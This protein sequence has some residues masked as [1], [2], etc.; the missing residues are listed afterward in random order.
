MICNQRYELQKLRIFFSYYNDYKSDIVK[1]IVEFL[2]KKSC[3]S[4]Q[5][6]VFDEARSFGVSFF[7]C[8]R[9]INYVQ[10]IFKTRRQE[11]S[12]KEGGIFRSAKSITSMR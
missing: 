4:S 11:I 6:G 7:G 3:C 8:G 10:Y 5:T 12:N 9:V 1:P 2:K